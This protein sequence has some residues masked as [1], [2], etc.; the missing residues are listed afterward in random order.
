M[1]PG[2][3][4][5]PMRSVPVWSMAEPDHV[6]EGPLATVRYSNLEDGNLLLRKN[7]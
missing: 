6:L 4:K 7:D 2:K 1:K 3:Q 5:E